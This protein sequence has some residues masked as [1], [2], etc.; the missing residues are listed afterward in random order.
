METL[1][2]D[3]G[4]A[5]RMLVNNPA[6]TAIAVLT[7]ALGIGAN[8]AIFTLV[9]ALLLKTL[10]VKAPQ[11]LVAVGNPGSVD[12]R[13]HGTPATDYF[14]YP[15]YRE[16][17]DR[18][19]VF[20]GL[21]A[22][23]S[24]DG[25]DVDSS[26]MG[27]ASEQRITA[28]LVSGNYF[29]VL[30]VKAAAGR[31]LTESDDTQDG[32]NPVLVLSYGYWQR[33]F[34][35]SPAVLGKTV[36]LN[37]S[38]FT[39]VGV[40]QPSFR[41]D[42]VGEESAVFVPLSMQSQIMRDS[43]YRND[44][45]ISWLLLLGRLK[46]GISFEQARANVNFAFQQAL[47]GAYGSSLRPEDLSD[48]KDA[49]ISV[50]PGA[51]GLSGLRAEYRLPVILLMGIVG[52]VLLIACVNVANLLLARSTARSKE[53]AV[54]MAIGASRA[55]LFRQFLTESVLLAFLGGACGVLLSIW[56]VRLLLATFSSNADSLPLSPDL[57]V[58]AFTMAVCLITGILFGL[59][60]ALR[61]AKAEMNSNLKNTAS[62]RT[63][64]GWSWG[65]GL[66]A[67]QVALSLLVL[68]G[69]MLLVR[70]L[71]KLMTQD[72]GYN[73]ARIVV[74]RVGASAGGYKGESLK[75]LARSLSDRLATIPGVRAASYS[76]N[77]LF[78]GGESSNAIL[79][80]GF[81]AASRDAR[82]AR[83]DSVGPG[84]FGALGIPILM[85]R[86][87]GPQD[88]ASSPRVAVVNQAMMKYFFR[89]ENPVGRQ[90]EID[91][92][93]EK[94]KLITVIGVAKDTKDHG[95]FLRE[96]PPPRVYVAFQQESRPVRFVLEV[97]AGGSADSAVSDVRSQIK[98]TDANLPIESVQTVT[99]RIENSMSSEIALARLSA[100]FAV[101]ALLLASIGLY[102]LM[103]YA[104]AGRAR[105]FG[106][107]MALGA[108]R[109]DVIQL[110]L[111]EGM[112]L[113]A[114]G[115][116]AGIPLALTASRVLRG[117]LFGLKSTDPLSL[118]VVIVV[119][120]GVS[121]IAG[122]IPARRA[123]KVDPMIALRYE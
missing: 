33:Q 34:A 93:E 118:I 67:G 96:N 75:Q 98:A 43:S 85:G 8:T 59:A 17:R 123:T 112:F 99:Q 92:P 109:K 69:A 6:F 63:R 103:S 105:E 102:G 104:V 22:A 62:G 7:L 122:F 52:L 3:F 115:L 111:R 53:V 117:F 68:F 9:N 48:I 16:L 29:P 31:L 110:V 70:S 30:G 15:L 46:P 107:R 56:G 95:E 88:T 121:A 120:G 116:A 97:V 27:S 77:G 42:V 50:S 51:T 82:E 37:G 55:R 74:A 87:I 4:Y 1:F 54:R 114:A 24:E 89:G 94:G 61:A 71:Q 36:R 66:I 19:I 20:H 13:W 11:E 10:P 73:S 78:S 86:G 108:R 72:L 41:G 21:V 76:R 5:L 28:R 25:V 14:S 119:L 44:P 100:F 23:A 18:T 40:A 26:S 12:T 84:Y 60:P 113:V 101:L 39:I 32:A 65:R 38:P 45:R 47:K 90:F 57:R 83:Q 35:L 49:R 2:Q 58:L 64:S 91:N 80:P 106:V 79:V 81:N